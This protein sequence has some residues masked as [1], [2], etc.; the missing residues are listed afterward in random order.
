MA[1]SEADGEWRR[2]QRMVA[3]REPPRTA[4]V[5]DVGASSKSSKEGRIFSRDTERESPSHP[6]TKWSMA[7]LE[8][9]AAVILVSGEITAALGFW[10]GRRRRL[11]Y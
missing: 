7:T 6:R 4:G 2:L 11:G 8:D 1:F 3:S 5:I 10:K 9:S